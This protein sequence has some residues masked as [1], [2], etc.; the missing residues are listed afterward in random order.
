MRKR[1]AVTIC[2]NFLSLMAHLAARRRA[3]RSRAKIVGKA[4]YSSS[5]GARR[6]SSIFLE[7]MWPRGPTP[8]NCTGVGEALA[9]MPWRA[10]SPACPENPLVGPTAG[11]RCSI[12]RS[13][14]RQRAGPAAMILARGTR[15]P[16]GVL[17]GDL[18]QSSSMPICFSGHCS[19]SATNC[20]V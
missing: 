3:F 10:I 14:R 16:R 11:G 15:S 20:R 5:R 13:A 1:V 7:G 19:S 2:R 6:R 17:A 12:C 9:K 8:R 4:L 18:R